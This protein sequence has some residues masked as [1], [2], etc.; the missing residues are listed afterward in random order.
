[1]SI[2]L[3]RV[4]PKGWDALGSE[5]GDNV[6]AVLMVV[7]IRVIGSRARELCSF[8]QAI[9]HK[10]LGRADTTHFRVWNGG[11]WV[12]AG[13]C[14]SEWRTVLAWARS[15]LLDSNEC[16]FCNLLVTNYKI[17]FTR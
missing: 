3:F 6:L 14:S 13:G 1:M 16:W 15:V 12:D 17:K 4:G 11:D 2:A 10:S 5:T 9:V 7:V 8:A